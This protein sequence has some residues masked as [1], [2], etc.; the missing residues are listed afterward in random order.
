MNWCDE[1][2]RLDTFPFEE[3]CRSV[4]LPA[5]VRRDEK[6]RLSYPLCER[7]SSKDTSATRRK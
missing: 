5:P 7:D 6:K 3:K 4:L 1:G 2:F